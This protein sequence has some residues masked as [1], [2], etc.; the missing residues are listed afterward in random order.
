MSS[1]KQWA[2]RLDEVEADAQQQIDAL[3]AERDALRE[4]AS[5]FVLYW[6]RDGGCGMCGGASHSST[7]YVGLFLALLDTHV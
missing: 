7:C 3:K 6:L 1:D 4:L 5:D 2:D